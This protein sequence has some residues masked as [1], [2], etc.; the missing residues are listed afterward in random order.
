MNAPLSSDHL[1]QDDDVATR[2]GNV[3]RE[4][5]PA[6]VGYVVAGTGLGIL[7]MQ[8]QVLSWFRIQEMFRFQSV[9]MFGIIGVAI[10]VAMTGRWLITRLAPASAAARA[11]ADDAATASTPM[12][13]HLLGGLVFGLGW[14]LLG[15]CPGPIFTLIGAGRTEY[16]VAL[17][18]ATL[19]TW[20]YGTL[21]S[22]L[23]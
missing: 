18:A 7:F 10:A 20:A 16:V 19:G 11:I 4:R 22:R 13:K 14:A 8:A 12:A 3:P 17:V 6:L 1:R 9:H 2:D 23:P 15:A 5:A 21:Q